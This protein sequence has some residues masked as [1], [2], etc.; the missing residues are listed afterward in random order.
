RRGGRGRPARG[1][2]PR[3]GAPRAGRHREALRTGRPGDA[4]PGARPAHGG[5]TVSRLVVT[6]VGVRFGG[7]A[8][9]E[10]ISLTV[11]PGAVTG[12]I[13][14]NGA[15]KTTLFNVVTGL[16]APASG[17]VEL[18]GR[19]VTGAPPHRRA[20][21]GLARTFQRLELFGSL[22]VRDNV[23]VGGDIRNGWGLPG[24]RR[25]R[26]ID[27]DAESERVIEMCGL[28]P[29]ADRQVSE[30]PTGQA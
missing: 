2:T 7:T 24:V 16:L 15:G 6:D 23:R 26:R 17:W 10:G 27:V 4:G 30:V 3:R 22:T 21:L 12:L 5:R 28:G 19:D 9:L 18:D 1:T 11:E 25:H 8:A 13:G 20:R 29:I 14:P